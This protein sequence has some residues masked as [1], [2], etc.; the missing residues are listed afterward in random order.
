MGK[1]SLGLFRLR[2]PF[3][4][5]AHL[6]IHNSFGRFFRTSFS[7]R[8]FYYEANEERVKK[9]RFLSFFYVPEPTLYTAFIP[10]FV[11]FTLENNMKSHEENL[12]WIV[13][14]ALGAVLLGFVLIPLRTVTSASNLAFVF[15]IFTI[16]VAE[17]GGRVAALST[18][19]ISAI[20]LNFFLTEPYLTLTI[21]HRD[22][23]IAFFALAICGLI[24]AAFGKKRLQWSEAAGRATERLNFLS[25]L[26]DQLRKERP[27]D[28]IVEAL[29]R[30]FGLGA[31]VLRD[32]RDH[33]LAA[34]PAGSNPVVPKTP[35]NVVTLFPD[36]ESH[37]RYGEQG[38]RLPEGG[39]RLSF[40][41]DRG[42][43]SLDLWEGDPQ[44]MDLEKRRVLAIAA[45]ILVLELSS[46]TENEKER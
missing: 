13:I 17:L 5:L 45:L 41:T 32:A 40:K 21:T 31:I 29:Q 28:E 27:L 14:G 20:S 43:I 36:E 11:F 9:P 15:L 7:G 10:S 46:R 12:V 25:R 34:A 39:G 4:N 35:L 42:S 16:I 33:I 18:A 19:L 6:G 30:N 44:G 38:F 26:V 22:D 1:I 8:L 2:R 24:A 37:Y 23:I 3:K